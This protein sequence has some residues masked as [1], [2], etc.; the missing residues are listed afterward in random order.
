[1]MVGQWAGF[2]LRMFVVWGEGRL[3]VNGIPIVCAVNYVRYE[4]L[5]TTC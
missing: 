2:I 3:Q 5:T 4:I 1:M